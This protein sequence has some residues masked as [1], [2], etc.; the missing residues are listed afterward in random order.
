MRLRPGLCSGPRWGDTHQPSSSRANTSIGQQSFSIAS[1]L[2]LQ[3]TS[4]AVRSAITATAELPVSY[5]TNSWNRM[6]V[7][8]HRHICRLYAVSNISKR[9]YGKRKILSLKKK[10]CRCCWKSRSYC[11]NYKLQQWNRCHILHIPVFHIRSMPEI[12]FVCVRVC[13]FALWITRS[14]GSEKI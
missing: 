7:H 1:I 10:P 12:R 9:Q 8:G 14:A 2:Q 5:A 4:F 3:C 13:L 11:T 6:L